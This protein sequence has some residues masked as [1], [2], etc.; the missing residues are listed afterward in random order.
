MWTGARQRFGHGSF[1]LKHGSVLA[2]RWAYEYLIGPIPATLVLDHLCR[3]TSCV[4]P[5]HVE[6]VTSG[7]NIM[8]GTAISVGYAQR[9][10]CV[11]GHPFD[12]TNTK[13]TATGR[14]CRAC[15]R[16]N[17]ATYAKRLKAAKT[18]VT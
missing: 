17:T 6:P 13:Q 15:S 12:D 3:T 4:H 7:V 14:I 16:R 1:R 10:M 18:G 8:R 9:S 2:H 5:L 11:H